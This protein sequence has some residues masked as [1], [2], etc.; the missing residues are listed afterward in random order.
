VTGPAVVALALIIQAPALLA[1]APARAIQTSVGRT[2]MVIVS[3]LGG[4]PQYAEQFHEWAIALDDAA[5]TTHGLPASA[6]TVLTEDPA[7]DPTRIQAKSTKDNVQRIFG[8]IAAGAA[9]DDQLFVVLIGHGSSR[10][11]EAKINLPGPDMTAADFAVLLDA[12]PGG[13]IVFVNTTSASG[14]FVEALAGS[15]RVIVTA[16]RSGYERN[17]AVF[18]RFF[19][20]A[21]AEGG[22]DTDKDGRLSVLEAFVFA[23][24]EVARAYE[25]GNTLQTEHAVLDDDGDGEGSRAPAAS[26]GD[27][28]LAAATFLGPRGGATAVAASSDPRLAPL[29][30]RQARIDEQIAALR[31]RKDSMN[32]EAYDRAL[33]DLLVDLA[34]NRRAIQEGAR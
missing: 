9:P 34:L 1:P 23:N 21:Y 28:G 30:E 18:G 20:E 6:V 19:V 32:E 22:S 27:G 4:E 5:R 31:G 2:Q 3:G 11:D 8:E 17:R 25:A 12:W 15:D 7:R 33:E 24:S 13:R 10:G 26:E 29:Y 14:G 16:T